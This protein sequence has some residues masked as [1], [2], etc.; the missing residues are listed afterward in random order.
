MSQRRRPITLP[1][2]SILSFDPIAEAT[3]KKMAASCGEERPRDIV[4][5]TVAQLEHAPKQFDYSSRMRSEP[6]PFAIRE[7]TVALPAVIAAKL[8]RECRYPDQKRDLTPSGQDHV[9]VLADIMNRG[10]WRPKD[11]IDLADLDGKITILNGHHR[12]AAQA[13]CGRQIEWMFVIHRCKTAEDLPALYYTFDTNL[14]ARS[15]HTILSAADAASLI[16]VCK[17]TAEALYRAAPVLAANF[18]F[19]RAARDPVINRVIDRRMEVMKAYQKEVQAWEAATDDAKAEVKRRLRNQGAMAVALVTFRYA[20][21]EAHSFW[22]GVAKD[23]GLRSGDPR[24]TFLAALRAGSSVGSAQQTAKQAAV[25]W[26][27]W[28]ARKPLSVIRVLE[29][30][31]FRIAGTPVGR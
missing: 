3:D 2:L 11:K 28:F 19:S 9:A 29:S 22:G 7:G 12:L 25:C 10:K 27:K 14:R 4:M 21:V 5:D 30:K 13:R 18:D 20:P 16:G 8:Y 15:N 24:H 31:E 23:D 17:T 6:E 1:E 26:N